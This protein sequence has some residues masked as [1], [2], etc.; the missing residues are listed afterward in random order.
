LTSYILKHYDEQEQQPEIGRLW[1]LAG[2]QA[3][4][5]TSASSLRPPT[6]TLGESPTICSW[7]VHNMPVNH[8]Q[9]IM[10]FKYFD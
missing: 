9:N 4:T 5:T 10:S 7:S 1:G 3:T 2:E 8:E 6:P